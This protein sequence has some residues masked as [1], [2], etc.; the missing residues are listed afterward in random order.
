MTAESQH[1]RSN[2][3][4][5][6]F[7]LSRRDILTLAVG[8]ATTAVVGSASTAFARA[9]MAK[10]TQEPL[11]IGVLTPLTGPSA[12]FG[13]KFRDAINLRFEQVGMK[14]GGRPVEIIFE[15][16]AGD[17]SAALDKV[18]KLVERDGVE[19]LMGPLN[20]GLMMGVGPYYRA[21]KKPVLSLLNHPIEVRD[22]QWIFTPQA[23]L[24]RVTYPMG[25]YAYD[26]MG[27]RSATVQ[28]ADYIG[29]RRMVAGFVEGLKSRGGKIVQEQ[30]APIGT[31][32]FG[33]YITNLVEADA[34][35][36]WHPAT[37]LAFMKQYFQ[38]GVKKPV[39]LPYA[40]I[41][42]EGMLGELGDRVMGL[43]GAINYTWRLDSPENKKFLSA[44]EG[45]YRRKPDVIEE[46][47]YEGASVIVKA[48]ESTEG[49]TTPAKLRKAILALK[50]TS[51]AGPV[52][53]HPS[54][55]GIRNVYIVEV[56]KIDG[57]LVW[58]PIHTYRDWQPL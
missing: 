43:K 10:T 34:V 7:R 17:L 47:A 46:G 15:D 9:A 50:F 2:R 58:E 24:E 39:I 41:L 14:A 1:P 51:P 3:S 57:R 19:I 55:F 22:F 29:G 4:D 40:D 16:E 52:S 45:K 28:G 49:D 30:Y 18:K 48:L 54:G 42:T 26:R 38:F 37:Q 12:F 35:A 20:S 53:F 56:K 25:L 31:G 13:P 36:T 27:I 6:P 21:N 11:K 5:T 8:S 33:P 23:P 44:F 32:D